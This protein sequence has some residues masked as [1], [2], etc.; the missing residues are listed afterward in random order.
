MASFNISIVPARHALTLSRHE[1][2]YNYKWKASSQSP[3]GGIGFQSSYSQIVI[4]HWMPSIIAIGSLCFRLNGVVQLIPNRTNNCILLFRRCIFPPVGPCLFKIKWRP[5][6]IHLFTKAATNMS[7]L[8]KWQIVEWHGDKRPISV[9]ITSANMQY[10]SLRLRLLDCLQSFF[11]HVKLSNTDLVC[12]PATA[13][14]Q[15]SLAGSTFAGKITFFPPNTTCS[16]PHR[17]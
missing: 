16:T 1:K 14:G 12:P 4:S 13:G 9:E 11:N 7:N 3:P 17:C 6:S 15:A 10:P 8:A 5:H 2:K